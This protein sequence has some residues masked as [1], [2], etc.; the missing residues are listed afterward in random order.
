MRWS[1]GQGMSYHFISSGVT[2]SACWLFIQRSSLFREKSFFTTHWGK[3]FTFFFCFLLKRAPTNCNSATLSPY[4]HGQRHKGIILHDSHRLF[5]TTGVLHVYSAAT[6]CWQLVF[7][8]MNS[9]SNRHWCFHTH[10]KPTP[11]HRHSIVKCH[12]LAHLLCS[13][14]TCSFHFTHS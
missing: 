11:P 1:A 12:F 6:I 13:R 2:I 10:P 9:K 5:P 4:E 7:L 3:F 8:N 14:G